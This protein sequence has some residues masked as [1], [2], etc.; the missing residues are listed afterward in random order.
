VLQ[1]PA[2]LPIFHQQDRALQTVLGRPFLVR[3]G[4]TVGQEKQ[5]NLMPLQT[6]FEMGQLGGDRIAKSA[7]E[8]PVH[9]QN[10]PA[11]ELLKS[12]S[13]SSK[14]GESEGG[15]IALEWQPARLSLLTR[16][17]DAGLSWRPT[18]LKLVHTEKATTLLLEYLI[19]TYPEA[20]EDQQEERYYHHLK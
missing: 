2:F 9:L 14:V 1:G 8:I 18:K 10:A 6:G 5:L 15:E 19:E 12:P 17:F 4:L 7:L 16:L 3:S 11:A 13:P 20:D